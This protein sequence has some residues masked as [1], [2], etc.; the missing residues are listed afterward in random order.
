MHHSMVGHNRGGE[1]RGRPNGRAYHPSENPPYDNSGDSLEPPYYVQDLNK[2][3]SLD[4]VKKMP[5][6]YRHGGPTEPLYHQP[7]TALEPQDR[8]L[9][10]R[11]HCEANTTPELL[12]PTMYHG[13]CVAEVPGLVPAGGNSLTSPYFAQHQLR[14]A[15]AGGRRFSPLRLPLGAS[16]SSWRRCSWRCTTVVFVCVTVCLA[17]VTTFLATSHVGRW[18]TSEGC[19]GMGGTDDSA[20]SS[21]DFNLPPPLQPSSPGNHARGHAYVAARAPPPFVNSLSSMSVGVVPGRVV[22]AARARGYTRARLPGMDVPHLPLPRA[23]PALVGLPRGRDGWAYPPRPPRATRWNRRSARSPRS[24]QHEGA[25]IR[26]DA[27]PPLTPQEVVGDMHAHSALSSLADISQEFPGDGQAAPWADSHSFAEP[28]G[29]VPAFTTDKLNALDT[30]SSGIDLGAAKAEASKQPEALAQTQEKL[31]SVNHGNG[32][33]DN[34]PEVRQETFAAAHNPRDSGGLGSASSLYPLPSHPPSPAPQLSGLSTPLLHSATLSPDPLPTHS[35]LRSSLSVSDPGSPSSLYLATPDA[36]PAATDATQDH[37]NEGHYISSESRSVSEPL[38]RREEADVHGGE[39]K[40]LHERWRSIMSDGGSGL[41][42][43]GYANAPRPKREEEENPSLENTPSY[44]HEYQ[45]TP[46]TPPTT[47]LVLPSFQRPT[48]EEG[49]AAT[50]LRHTDTLEQKKNP[51]TSAGSDHTDLPLTSSSSSSSS[52]SAL[53]SDFDVNSSLSRD[54]QDDPATHHQTRPLDSSSRSRTYAASAGTSDSPIKDTDSLSQYV[55]PHSST[56]AGSPDSEPLQSTVP[57]HVGVE[58]YTYISDDPGTFDDTFNTPVDFN[59]RSPHPHFAPVDNVVT[60]TGTLTTPAK[61]V[62]PPPSFGISSDPTLRNNAPTAT[63]TSSVTA[64]PMTMGHNS[65]DTPAL[66]KLRA[67]ETPEAVVPRPATAAHERAPPAGVTSSPKTPLADGTINWSHPDV[68]N[69]NVAASYGDSL[70]NQTEYGI[71]RQPQVTQ[72]NNDKVRE[73]GGGETGEGGGGRGGETEAQEQVENYEAME[74]H[75]DSEGDSGMESLFDDGTYPY[76]E[77]DFLIND[78]P[79]SQE[80]APSEQGEEDDK[81]KDLSISPADGVDGP[82]GDSRVLTGEGQYQ[83]DQNLQ[84]DHQNVRKENQ[85]HSED[86]LS[87]P[88]DTDHQYQNESYRGHPSPSQSSILTTPTDT[89][90]SLPHAPAPTQ[91]SQPRYGNRGENTQGIVEG[92][93]REEDQIPAISQRGEDKQDGGYEG[94]E[95]GEEEEQETPQMHHDSSRVLEDTILQEQHQSASHPSLSPGHHSGVNI[96]PRKEPLDA[97]LAID[98][99]DREQSPSNAHKASDAPVG[100]S[101]VMTADGEMRSV[102][103]TVSPSVSQPPFHQ[104]FTGSREDLEEEEEREGGIS[105]G[106]Q[107]EPFSEQGEATVQVP[108][109]SAANNPPHALHASDEISFEREESGSLAL[110]VIGDISLHQKKSSIVMGEASSSSDPLDTATDRIGI[111]DVTAKDHRPKITNKDF[112]G[113]DP[114]FAGNQSVESG[115]HPRSSP[116]PL[117]AHSDQDTALQAE[118]KRQ[119]TFETEYN[120]QGGIETSA[121]RQSV[122]GSLEASGYSE[123]KKLGIVTTVSVAN[124]GHHFLSRSNQVAGNPNQESVHTQVSSQD[125]AGGNRQDQIPPSRENYHEEEEG[126]EGR[127]EEYTEEDGGNFEYYLGSEGYVYDDVAHNYDDVFDDY[128]EE[129][130]NR[131]NEAYDRRHEN[132]REGT[133][134]IGDRQAEGHYGHTSEYENEDR[135]ENH[136]G[137][138][139]PDGP[140]V[141]HDREN[142][143]GSDGVER[144]DGAGRDELT[145]VSQDQGQHHRAPASQTPAQAQGGDS[146]QIPAPPAEAHQDPTATA[147]PDDDSIYHR[148]EFYGSTQEGTSM[149]HGDDRHTTGL[150]AGRTGGDERIEEEEEERVEGE[151]IPLGAPPKEDNT[152]AVAGG[153]GYTTCVGVKNNSSPVSSEGAGGP[154]GGGVVGGGREG[155]EGDTIMPQR[156]HWQSQDPPCKCSCPCEGPGDPPIM[157]GRVAANLNIGDPAISDHQEPTTTTTTTT[158]TST[159]TTTTT[160]SPISPSHHDHPGSHDDLD[161]DYDSDGHDD[162]TDHD[163]AY[164]SAEHH[165]DDLDHGSHDH[166]RHHRHRHHHGEED[167]EYDEDDERERHRGHTHPHRESDERRNRTYVP[168]VVAGRRQYFASVQYIST[169]EGP[170]TSYDPHTDLVESW[171]NAVVYDLPAEEEEGTDWFRRTPTDTTPSA[172]TPGGASVNRPYTHM[173]PDGSS[174]NPLNLGEKKEFNLAPYGYWNIHLTLNDPTDLRIVLSVPRGT[175]LGLYARRGKLPTH[176]QH[177]I[178]KIL[179]GN[180][181]RDIRASSVS[182]PVSMVELTVEEVLEAG[183]WFLSIYNDD[184]DPHQVNLVIT[185]G[186]GGGECPQRCHERGNCILGRCQCAPGY[187]GIDCSQVLCPIL[188][189]GH[190]AYVGGQ[191]ICHPGFKGKECQLRHHE[192]EV[193]DCHGQGHCVDGRCKCAKGYT[194]EFCQTVDCPNPKCSGHGWCVM[195]T[196]VC[197]KGWR[198]DD[199]SEM[200]VDA[201]QCLPDCSGHGAFSIEAHACVCDHLWTGSDCSKK[202]CSLDCG[203]HGI[204]ENDACT[205]DEGWTGANCSERLCDPRCSEHGQCKNGTC[206]CMAGW[207]GRHCTLSGCPGNCRNRGTCDADQEGVWKCLCQ[208]GW[209][210]PDCSAMLETQC[211]DGVDNDRDGLMDCQ[212]PECCTHQACQDS[213]LCV[214]RATPMD[215]LLRKQPPGSTASFFE[216]MRFLIEEDSLQH[217]SGEFN[218]SVIWNHFHPRRAAVVRGRVVTKA[219]RGLVGLRVGTSNNNE[220]FTLTRRDGWFDIMVNGGGAVALDFG[221]PP[222]TSKQIRVMVPWN[223]MVVLD[224]IVMTV[225]GVPGHNDRSDDYHDHQQRRLSSSHCPLHDY[226]LLKPVVMATWQNGFQGECPEVDAILV[227]AQAVQ[228]SVRIPGTGL[229]LVYHSSRANGYESTL[230]LQLT[231]DRI[232][233]S[234]R[235]VHLRIVLE[236]ILFRKVFEADPAIK[237][238]YAWNRM[239]VYRQSVYGVTVARVSVGYEHENCPKIIWEHQT[240]RVAGYDLAIS[241]VG[242]FNLHVHHAYNFHQ[243][244]LQKGDGQN[245]HLSGQRH[246]VTTLLGTGEQREVNCGSRC[247]GRAEHSPLH[248]PTCLAAA[249]DGSLYV[250]DFN[251]IRRVKPDGTVITVAK[252]NETRVSYRYHVAVSPLDGS[253]Y[254][255]DPEAHQVLR[256]E[257]TDGV[258]DPLRNTVT[259]VGSGQ[260]CLPGDRNQCGDGGMARHA[261]LTYPKGLAISSS[262][263]IYIADGTNIRVVSPAGDIHTLIGGH[264]HRSHWAPVPCN[265]TINIDQLH[266]RWPTELAISPLDGS[267]HILDDHLVLR[268]TPDNRVQVLTG[269]SLNCPLPPHEPSD[270]SQTALLLNPQ[271]IAFSPQGE[272]YIAESDTQRINRV[273]II[274][275]DGRISTF[276]GADPGCNCRDATCYC[277][278]YDNVSATSAIFSSISSIAVTPDG[279]LHVSDQAGYRVRSVRSLLPELNERKQYEIFSPDTHEVYVFNRFGQH[280][281]THNLVTGQTIYK[282]SYSDN[283]NTGKLLTVTDSASN[284]FQIIRDRVGFVKAIENPQKQRVQITLSMMKM[285]QQLVAPDG[286]NITFNYHGATGCMRS[287]VEA[288]GRSYSYEYDAQGRLTQAVLPTGQVIHLNF[289]L[290]VRG[291]EVTVTRDGKEPVITRLRGN[292]FN[293]TS[294]PVEALAEMGGQGQ[295]RILTAWKHE[296]SLERTAYRVLESTSPT[297][298]E[299]FPVLS[300]QQTHISGN[301]VNRYEWSYSPATTT[302]NHNGMKVSGT[303][304]VNGADLLTLSYDPVSS[305][306]ALLSVSGHMLV[307]ITYDNLGRPIRWVPV[308]PLVAS[309][310]TYDHWGHIT[311]WVRGNLS[312]DYYYD[313]FLRLVAVV[314]ADGKDVKYEYRSHFTKPEKVTHPS[315]RAYGL[316]YDDAGSLREVVTPRG[317]AYTLQLS[318]S[319]GFYRLRLALPIDSIAL[320]MRLDEQGR[321]L[322]ITLPGRGGTLLYEYNDAGQVTAELYGHG[323]TEYSYYDTGLM[324]NAKTKHSHFDLRTD[325]HYHGG[326][327]KEMK[328]RYGPKSSLHNAKLRFQYDGSARLRKVEGEVDSTPLAEMYI[329]FDNQT[330]VLQGISDLR[331]IRNNILET[332]IQNP[333]KHYVNTRKQDNYGRLSEVY[334]TLGDRMVFLMQ[335]KYDNRNRISERLIEVAG[336]REGLNITYM[337]DGQILGAAGKIIWL[338]SYDENGNVISYSEKSFRTNLQYDECDRVTMV[339]TSEVEYD[340]RGFVIRIDNQNFDFNTKGQLVAAW[341]REQTWSFRI[342]YDHFDR[343]SVYEDHHENITQLIYGRPDQPHLV[344]HL[345]NPRTGATTTLLYDDMNHLIAVD[346]PDGRY[347]VATDQNGTPIA[348]FNDMGLLIRKQAWTPFGKLLDASGENMWVGIGPWGGFLEPVTGIVVLKGHAYHPQLLQWLTP[349]WG[350][351][352]QTT[353][354][355]TDVFVYRFMNNNPFNPQDRLLRHYYTNVSEWLELYGIELR[356]VLGSEYHEDTM[357]KPRAVVSVDTL[358][359]SEVVSGLWCQYRAGIRHLHGLSFFSQSHIQRQMGTWNGAPISRQASIF[360]PGVLVSN[361][362]GRVLVTGVGDDDFAGVIGD[363]IRTVLNNSIILDVSSTQ[364]GLDTFYFI[365]DNRKR[366]GEDMQHLRRLS[367]IFNISD[368]ETERGHEIRMSTP[369]ANLVIMYGERVQRARNRVLDEMEQRAAR[370]AWQREVALVSLG[371]PGTHNWSPQEAAELVREG[372]VPGYVATHLHPASRYPLLAADPSNIIFKHETSRKRRK[373]RRKGRKRSWRQRKKGG[374]YEQT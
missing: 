26:G 113:D 13:G 349:Q 68:N 254:V 108:P 362:D 354:H 285:L 153:G 262:G 288:V 164:D 121:G 222:F 31:I 22:D 182:T 306:E 147:R 270:M 367:G 56:S 353:R 110:P 343:V 79:H 293:H 32:A 348:F 279:V 123:R 146:W 40:G 48:T 128:E 142:H 7:P 267:L 106:M 338:Y 365:K 215:I 296:V 363:V 195:G 112:P 191:C 240:A 96:D 304:R 137:N 93:S 273:R 120:R 366:A 8:Y 98:G 209:D 42:S 72:A 250:G 345:H 350:H 260:R 58:E 246:L 34:T 249:P 88:L 73:S 166:D 351:L 185:R 223:E 92:F 175:N 43:P 89:H 355:V 216:K 6:D 248:A 139:Q 300:R 368:S 140:P 213:Q 170:E 184:G 29:E 53:S 51:D 66:V 333:K 46:E 291:A 225:S 178:M 55:I 91:D 292:T 101:T 341:D 332:M 33:A 176:T 283:S 235:R 356:L 19:L 38:T 133:G 189:S 324:R 179:R 37:T 28:S 130:G 221:K 207:N 334:M 331:I 109:S 299:M 17:A 314:Y 183:E 124:Q 97:Y 54:L 50:H 160:A 177:D 263:E 69:T 231:P 277:H 315:G 157:P 321:V 303:L 87:P 116:S 41:A 122:S 194:G 104:F 2:H 243:G 190:G 82:P 339:G 290:S 245:I 261:R 241:S 172:A 218:K 274:T 347:F 214:S 125:P 168:L 247:E 4:D 71:M 282:F 278:T 158:T 81:K 357:V 309:N 117:D 360:G 319:L 111:N 268:V 242:G 65:A 145:G 302:D 330:G 3:R 337:P 206:V 144:Q 60:S 208:P 74:H 358:G 20:N 36:S 126:G 364:N 325:Y 118:Y 86:G 155:G 373:S 181:Q 359:A 63:M 280:L 336:R 328:L 259:V 371:R 226:D 305:T 119:E 201:Q 257:N 264:D 284:R 95:E 297:S 188:C 21:P 167:D 90:D 174:F 76:R 24:A 255:S 340:E 199:C 198:G 5:E 135:Q 232:P 301:T 114:T 238:T 149:T 148:Q 49:G 326:L 129:E 313:E 281:E 230:R 335:L 271:S 323:L 99:P 64:L 192:C 52:T 239:N 217:F 15:Q 374:A 220:G 107:R 228:E 269:R 317:S 205:C 44:H 187:S 136:E 219:G 77:L 165:H 197:Q 62:T 229:Y 370:V 103:T 141:W 193:P 272:L 286:Y 143:A 287:K 252:L 352:T 105:T 100:I 316:V 275:S 202:A 237:F 251:L 161:F 361:I 35:Q 311:S 23:H 1:G 156:E 204:C 211:S 134:N 342:G 83:A 173:P 16:G 312:E 298:A 203:P 289:D 132:D 294:G 265:G 310:V 320:Q 276:A 10:K 138:S 344:T 30:R 12:F 39:G 256:L 169:D 18:H 224:D 236:G 80:T 152:S 258:T 85:T 11:L 322:A 14:M 159:T 59:V 233:S 84:S 75:W 171:G 307:N 180:R 210:G 186:P 47:P 318:T 327:M 227:E 78:E 295:L 346:Q 369:T 196:C 200:D 57:H 27:I 127:G 102:A 212:D 151:N 234:L 25:A 94:R 45:V 154:G 163:S 131:K 266:L 244:I 9:S 61:A 372:R 67:G 70:A 162:H 150:A 308:N 115:M 329:R 253:V